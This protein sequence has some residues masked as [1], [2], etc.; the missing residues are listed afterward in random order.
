MKVIIGVVLILVCTSCIPMPTIPEP[1][2]G[3]IASGGMWV[4]CEGQWRQNNATLSYIQPNDNVVRDAMMFVNARS[5]GDTP[6]DLLAVSDTLCIAVNT[7][8]KITFVQRSTG[9][10]LGSVALPDNK[11]PYRL[12]NSGSKLWCTNLNDDS[13]TEFDIRSGAVTVAGVHVGPAPEGIGAADGKL[14]VALSGLGDLRHMEDGAGT[15]VVLDQR[16][17]HAI[18]TIKSLPNAGAV[19]A[20]AARHHVWCAYRNLPSATDQEGGV[21]VID[22]RTDTVVSHWRFTAPTTMSLD[23]L[24]GDV[25]V[26]HANGV[27]VI[28]PTSP[29][30]RRIVSHTNTSLDQAWYS[31]AFDGRTGDLFIGNAGTYLTDGEVLRLSTN[32]EV[33]SRYVVGP[34]P[35]KIL[36]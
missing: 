8:R 25:Y 26:L 27:D 34:N 36:P 32:G 13:I 6:S 23:S 17:L 24:S 20:D 2:S 1:G 18:D 7:S 31:I 5:I 28:S 33:R 9:T 21:V 15:V 4:L 19:I 3:T 29:I 10:F 11:E 12:A 16:D 22:S 30:S 14:Y 35:T